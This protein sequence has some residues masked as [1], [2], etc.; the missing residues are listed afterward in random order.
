MN[1][2][3]KIL[4]QKKSSRKNS[5]TEKIIEKKF[6]LISL[7]GLNSTMEMKKGR[8]SEFTACSIKI[9]QSKQ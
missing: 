8:I 3:E 1:V 2:L 7:E 9:T 6:F 5:R 4:E